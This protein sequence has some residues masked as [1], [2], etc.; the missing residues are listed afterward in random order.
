MRLRSGLIKGVTSVYPPKKLSDFRGLTALTPEKHFTHTIFTAK[1]DPGP[2]F[3]YVPAHLL[4]QPYLNIW[5]L[6]KISNIK[7]ALKEVIAQEGFRLFEPAQPKTRLVVDDSPRI[8]E[9]YV[10]SKQVL[11]FTSLEDIK[12]RDGEISL[13]IDLEYGLYRGLGHIVV[14]AK[15]FGETD[16]KFENIGIDQTR[17]FI[18]LDGGCCFAASDPNFK[19]RKY[20]ITARGINK[21]PLVEDEDY[22]AHNWLDARVYLVEKTDTGE[23]TEQ[24]IQ[25][26]TLFGDDFANHP[27]FRREVNE[28]LLQILI[29]PQEWLEKFVESCVP[30]RWQGDRRVIEVTEECQEQLLDRQQ[31][32]QAAAMENES[33]K[34]YLKSSAA[35]ALL[36]K[37]EHRVFHPTG[38]RE[39]VPDYAQAY[40]KFI[41]LRMQVTAEECRRS[42]CALI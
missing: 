23:K 2:D 41:T 7:D 22:E 40:T 25:A 33:F 21:L 28:M 6:K 30:D 10:A 1:K 19:S 24:K 16:L 13:K 27:D 14:L 17:C 20:V 11:A 38:K 8:P 12:K 5:Y 3:A 9:W 31:Q 34:A 29:A 37:W 15:W 32:F 36:K 39:L 35:E 26:S 4:S 18:K 42:I